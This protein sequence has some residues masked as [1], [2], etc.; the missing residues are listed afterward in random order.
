[1]RKLIP[2]VVSGILAV[3]AVGC[4]GG[5]DTATT[6]PG[7]DAATKVKDA[8]AKTGDAAKD[9]ANKTGDAVKGAADKTTTAVKDAADKTKTA[10]QSASGVKTIVTNRLK[11][12]FPGSDLKVEDKDGAL[13]I[14]G[15]VP[16][17]DVAKKLEPAVKEYK[18]QG[19]KT[20]K[21]DVKVAEKKPQ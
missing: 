19:V 10:V 14:T 16:S 15:T 18:L 2:F 4:Q 13:T 5:S 8:A 12:K 20:V 21:V 1:M 9:A 17:A 7:P 6:T 3:T 11:E